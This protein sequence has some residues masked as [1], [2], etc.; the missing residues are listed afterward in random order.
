MKVTVLR[1]FCIGGGKDVQP[2]DEIDLPEKEALLKTKQGKVRDIN[3]AAG[4]WHGKKRKE[5]TI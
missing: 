3:V 1:G 2:G 4:D 5:K